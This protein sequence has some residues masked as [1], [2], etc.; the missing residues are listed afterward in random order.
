ML[1]LAVFLIYDERGPKQPVTSDH[2][3]HPSRS[4]PIPCCQ[5][6]FLIPKRNSFHTNHINQRE[7]YGKVQTATRGGGNWSVRP[8]VAERTH[9]CTRLQDGFCNPI[10]TCN[11]RRSIDGTCRGAKACNS[12]LAFDGG[13]SLT[14]LVVEEKSW[15]G[16]NTPAAGWFVEPIS[17]FQFS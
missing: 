16:P 8:L 14:G 4:S 7:R 10:S 17:R 2:T 12:L 1:F 15:E 11:T 6:P 5:F 13:D 3:V 9:R